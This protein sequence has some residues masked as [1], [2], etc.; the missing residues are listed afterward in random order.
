MDV[1]YTGALVEVPGWLEG[2][3][4]AWVRLVGPVRTDRAQV[5]VARRAGAG[6][7]GVAFDGSCPTE[8]LWAATLGLSLGHMFGSDAGDGRSRD[9]WTFGA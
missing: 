4:A 5:A 2:R 8:L 6:R 3:E 1:S 7:L 9:D